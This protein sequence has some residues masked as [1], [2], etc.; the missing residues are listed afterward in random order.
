[1]RARTLTA[2]AAAVFVG[3]VLLAGGA[4]SADAPAATP[5]QTTARLEARISDLEQVVAAH[6]TVIDETSSRAAAALSITRCIRAAERVAVHTRTV[7]GR[8]DGFI[9]W[10]PESPR[11]AGS[12]WV[13]VVH[14]GC[15]TVRR[16]P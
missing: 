4:L 5:D 3:V 12:W 13:P 7:N 6:E 10:L 11:V 14:P 2:I 1:M 8:R 15:V 9:V 16:R